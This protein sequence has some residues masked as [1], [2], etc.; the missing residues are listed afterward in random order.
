MEEFSNRKLMRRFGLRVVSA[1]LVLDV[2]LYVTV[3]RAD[4]TDVDR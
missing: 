3:G 1:S 2:V 4:D